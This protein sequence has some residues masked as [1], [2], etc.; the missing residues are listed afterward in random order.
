SSAT[1]QGAAECTSRTFGCC[2]DGV[3]P[4]RGRNQE[5]CP[6]SG[7]NSSSSSCKRAKYGCC[8]DGVTAAT[9]PRQQG[10]P[11]DESAVGNGADQGTG[12]EKGC[13]GSRYGCC[14]DGVTEA[15]G[16]NQEGCQTEVKVTGK[17]CQQ[18]YHGCCPHSSVA[19]T[20]PNNEGC[21]AVATTDFD[22]ASCAGDSDKGDCSDY[23][24]QWYY[25]TK[26]SSC[27]RFWYGGC[28]G[29]GNRFATE[30]QCQLGCIDTTGPAL[31]R[32]P[33]VTGPCRARHQRFFF[34]HTTGKCEKFFYGGCKGNTNRFRSIAECE[35]RC[36][37]DSPVQPSQPDRGNEISPSNQV[38]LCAVSI[39]GCC[40]DG[41][42]AATGPNKQG[43]AEPCETAPYGCCEDGVTTAQGPNNAGCPEEGS[44]F[45][46][47]ET[48]Q[49]GCCADGVTA[50]SGPNQRGC[51]SSTTSDDSDRRRPPVTP[52]KTPPAANKCQSPSD[53]GPCQDYVVRWF[54]KS[55]RQECAQ[56]WFG[57][58][59]G[60]G[61]NFETRDECEAECIEAETDAPATEDPDFVSICDMPQE[62]G[63]CRAQVPRWY[64]SRLDR[65]CRT[66]M[67]G[68]CQG[69]ENNF[70]SLQEC[71]QTFEMTGGDDVYEGAELR[72]TCRAD[73]PQ[74]PTHIE[75]FINGKPIGR[76]QDNLS[77]QSYATPSDHSF[78]SELIIARS[79]R[80][81]SATYYCRSVPY[82]DVERKTVMVSRDS[83]RATP[84]PTARP[85]EAPTSRPDT[86]EESSDP[87]VVCRM[88]QKPGNCRGYFRNY[89]Y[90]A[91]SMSCR[92]FVY[93]GCDGNS[94]NFP[95]EAACRQYCMADEVCR[96][97]AVTGNCRARLQRWYYDASYQTCREFVYGGCDG[98]S[99]NFES[100]QDCN[101]Y[102]RKDDTGTSGRGS[103]NP[104]DVCR[105]P[106]ETGNCRAYLQR[107]YYDASYQACRQF[108]YG[109]CDGNSNNFET[110]ED[111]NKYCR[112]GG[113][114]TNLIPDNGNTRTDPNVVC[115][116]AMEVG[117]CRAALPRWHYDHQ[118]GMCRR[119]NYGGCNGNSNNFESEEDCNNYCR[120]EDICRQPKETGPCR[121][122]LQRYYYDS[123][124]GQCEQF[125]YG[126]C[127]GNLNNFASYEA[128]QRKCA[129]GG[130]Y[131]Q[132]KSREVC[133][134][135]PDGG[136]C[137]GYNI[138]WYY[139]NAI[140]RCQQF[141]YGG[142]EGNG[143]QFKTEQECADLC[144]V[145]TPQPLPPTLPPTVTRKDVCK[146]PRERG[147][148]SNYTIHWYYDSDKGYC[149]RFYY[150]GCGGNGNRF[151]SKEE[152]DQRCVHRQQEPETTTASTFQPRV[153]CDYSEF[154]CC[155]DGYT[156]A[157]DMLRTNCK[158]ESV[159][160]RPSE[161][162]NQVLANRGS[163]AYL[164]CYSPG[165]A[166]SWYRDGYYLVSDS[167][168][169]IFSNGTLVIS[170]IADD[171]TGNYACRISDGNSIPQVKRYIV[172][173]KMPLNILQTPP[174]ISVG[175]GENAYLH[176]QAFGTPTPRVTW[177][178]QGATVTSR[179][180]RIVFN[181]GTLVVTGM[182]AQ[183]TGNYKCTAENGVDTPVS[184]N[185]KLV[186]EEKL[187]ASILPHTEK[188]MEG[189]TAELRCEVN[190]YPTP[191]VHW[192]KNGVMITNSNKMYVSGDTLYVT[193]VGIEDAGLYSCVAT[194]KFGKARDLTSLQVK[195]QSHH[196]KCVNTMDKM[197]CRLIVS[198]RLCGFRM[199]SK[200]CC[201]SCRRAGL[202][203]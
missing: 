2:P 156:P 30:E 20:G 85:T 190:G 27:R 134:L 131:I 101:N 183:D 57:G 188:V 193:R 200:K 175:P 109:G 130:G 179:G 163:T 117:S 95:S 110:E 62:T 18:S 120:T 58:C 116:Q 8:S 145:N 26:T 155:D 198:A 135:D 84:R 158:D 31:C 94:N 68:G 28:G 102:C 34:N 125:L 173:L 55:E 181:N 49:F 115:Q 65:Q 123:A 186:I 14:P 81:N 203:R 6:S 111:C 189:E 178:Y 124:S 168:F 82:S 157:V 153:Q 98:N 128:C 184:R 1:N 112:S 23:S 48:S 74:T 194:N 105:L 106:S 199:F 146:M 197:K 12:R 3:T 176:C 133:D 19:A 70:M 77:I 90:D 83:P 79:T 147:G 64:Y 56:F 7:D 44:G 40:P 137:R 78:T 121:S 187:S 126:G 149:T 144:V 150:G 167:R 73:G 10:C 91:A 160:I 88:P 195:L 97:P 67:Y 72:L 140:R 11:R 185:M 108:V 51:S 69:N 151:D 16:Y 45:G 100:E 54:Y 63:P 89:Y 42:T 141:I 161:D 9:G 38:E 59:H 41:I 32:L 75:W 92:E 114:D 39:H 138:L 152:C 165:S 60:N 36:Q 87:R 96:L 33:A 24:V 172:Q 61:N 86:R 104:D 142:C 129:G 107:W 196:D 127:Q 52:S 99:N 93:T 5:G 35:T 17:L 202:I 43:C 171:V 37:S 154:G 162:G 139:D 174:K 119:F 143:N 21:D 122:A 180:R 177:S 136:P 159:V 4:A 76:Q 22:P 164:D 80:E 182:T 50:A 201:Q 166:I 25:D 66:F 169:Q 191:L 148:C 192:E 47:C 53:R 113:S 103:T 170:N 132:P 13:K 15:R 46:D 29:N 118:E 71:Q